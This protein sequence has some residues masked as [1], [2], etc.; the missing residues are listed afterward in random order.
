MNGGEANTMLQ[1]SVRPIEAKLLALALDPAAKGGEIVTA[2]E[3]LIKSLR[4]RGVSAADMFRGFKPAT[5][6]KPARATSDPDLERA[7]AVRMPFGK[8]KGK[9]LRD[10]PLDYLVWVRIN[11]LNA[12]VA[13][14]RAIT[15]V[16]D[17]N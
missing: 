7:F 9:Q 6:F 10:V 16:L 13:L 3:K 17:G 8:Y 1:L 11:C 2:A 15:R 12:S 14:R 5:A 4:E